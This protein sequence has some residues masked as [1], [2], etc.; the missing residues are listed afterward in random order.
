MTCVAGTGTFHDRRRA[1][2]NAFACRDWLDE[3]LDDEL[4]D[5]PT[6]EEILGID[7][8][9]ELDE[10]SGRRAVVYYFKDLKLFT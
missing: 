2:E 10:E 1:N 6:L 8:M 4:P 9:D 7:T 3:D 5:P